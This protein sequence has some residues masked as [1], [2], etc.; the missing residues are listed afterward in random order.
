MGN[1]CSSS[2]KSPQ[3]GSSNLTMVHR[4]N[5]K[6]AMSDNKHINFSNVMVTSE[7][8]TMVLGASN[9]NGE[10]PTSGSSSGR[11]SFG[12][13]PKVPTVLLLPHQH[14]LF[15]ERKQRVCTAV[16]RCQEL[17]K[18]KVPSFPFSRNSCLYCIADSFISTIVVCRLGYFYA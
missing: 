13:E 18:L 1:W 11:G 9:N 6:S 4:D 12:K 10:V 2:R 14:T 15:C 3:D 8:N 17:E 7:Y 5:P 16:G